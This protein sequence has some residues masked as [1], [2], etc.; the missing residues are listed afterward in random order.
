M[1]RAQ[2]RRDRKE[3]RARHSVHALNMK[4]MLKFVFIKR[5]GCCFVQLTKWPHKHTHVG[6]QFCQLRK[7]QPACMLGRVYRPVRPLDLIYNSMAFAKL[8]LPYEITS[9]FHLAK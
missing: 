1:L 4:H 8:H 7:W 6:C 3:T 9:L 5:F 2:T